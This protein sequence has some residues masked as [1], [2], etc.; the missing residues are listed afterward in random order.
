M[1][2]IGRNDPCHCGSGKK[3]KQCCADKDARLT[4]DSISNKSL[5]LQQFQKALQQH[6]AG[7]LSEASTLYQQILQVEPDHTDALHLLALIHLTAGN[8]QAALDLINKALRLRPGEAIYLNSLGNVFKAQGRSNEA[9]DCY[10]QA[11]LTKPDFAEA[12]NNLG[13]ICEEEGRSDDAVNYYQRALSIK[14]DYLDA[15][16]NLGRALQ[17]QGHFDNAIACYEQALKINPHSVTART[18]LGSN[19]AAQGRMDEALH[20]CRMSIVTRPNNA[21]AYHNLATVLHAQGL[22]DEAITNYQLA[23]QINPAFA[24]AH[25]NLGLA[26]GTQGRLEEA[27]ASCRKAIAIKPDSVE[28]YHNLGILYTKQLQIDEALAH[29][30]QAFSIKPDYIL[31]YSNLILLMDADPRFSAEDIHAEFKHFSDAIESPLIAGRKPHHNNSDRDRKLKIGYVSPDFCNHAVSP[32]MLPIFEH[33]DKSQSTLYGYYTNKTQDNISERIASLMDEWIPCYGWSDER[34]AERIRADGIDILVDLSGHTTANRLA[35][36]ARKP[37]PI[38]VTWI[39]YP[40]TTGLNAMDYRLTDEYLDPPGATDQY[41]TEQLI[42]LSKSAAYPIPAT[43]PD[44]NQLPAL[45]SGQVT[46]ACL[47][48][49]EK[50]NLTVVKLWARIL[51]AVPQAKLMLL[52]ADQEFAS[53]RLLQMLSQHGI[54]M[55]R[56]ILQPKVPFEDYLTLHHQIDL[57]LDCFPYNGATTTCCSLWMGVPVVTLAGSRPVSRCGAS[58]LG[59]AGLPEFITHSEDEYLRR[60]LEVIGNLPKLNQI[61]QSLRADLI[62]RNSAEN[63]VQELET[64]FRMMWRTWCDSRA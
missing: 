54:G 34:L 27:I 57:A 62:S 26:L 15:Q 2:K 22:L 14:P 53:Q 33:H 42:R 58:I 41:H 38:Q 9:A 49:A 60:A 1:Q 55:E 17:A 10:R 8:S 52:Y 3:Y 44:V 59:R 51:N 39:G 40:S 50:I 30:R 20:H 47:N 64:A 37:A 4:S 45:T 19:L 5:I 7:Q 25:Y 46:F 13:V 18:N 35:V 32:F 16:N 23:L 11:V 24:T 56:L 31:S 6:Q 12:Q 36:F 28:A 48:R 29:Y 63:Y 21:D 61:R 43:S